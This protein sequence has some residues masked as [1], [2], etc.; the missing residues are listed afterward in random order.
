MRPQLRLRTL[1]V[2]VTL[3]A[4]GA[5]GWRHYTRVYRPLLAHR[6][7]VQQCAQ[8]QAMWNRVS[9]DIPDWARHDMQIRETFHQQKV[10][11][12]ER[13]LWQPWLVVDPGDWPRGLGPRAVP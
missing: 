7:H 4:L 2:L 1:F 13:A 3:C 8:V 9:F 6:H 5:M 10:S 12:Y 11:E